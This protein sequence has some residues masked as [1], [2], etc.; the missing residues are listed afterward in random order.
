MGA[1]GASVGERGAG[2]GSGVWPSFMETSVASASRELHTRLRE[3]SAGCVDL[4]QFHALH[5]DARI[6]RAVGKG[7]F[8]LAA[9]AASGFS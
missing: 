1:V 6:T 5:R 8:R 9:K 7:W 4:L 2:F 3:G